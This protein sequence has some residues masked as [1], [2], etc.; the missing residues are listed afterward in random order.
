MI[1]FTL[2]VILWLLL[3]FIFTIH[4]TKKVRKFILTEQKKAIYCAHGDFT[5]S[6]VYAIYRELE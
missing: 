5:A 4:Y 6:G 1:P 2:A 3:G